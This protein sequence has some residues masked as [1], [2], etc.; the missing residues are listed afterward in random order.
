MGPEGE[1]IFERAYQ[2]HLEE[3]GEDITFDEF[4]DR[5]V[6]DEEFAKYFDTLFERSKK[7]VLDERKNNK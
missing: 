1:K 6:S 7:I 4:F 5:V 3:S 2:L